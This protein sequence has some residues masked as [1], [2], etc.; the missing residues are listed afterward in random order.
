MD[1]VY[2]KG[3]AVEERTVK[4]EAFVRVHINGRE[5]VW[6]PASEIEERK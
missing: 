5:D 1:K 2:I 6:I 4:G 3:E